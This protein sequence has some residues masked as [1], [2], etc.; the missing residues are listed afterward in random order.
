M[1]TLDPAVN[2]IIIFK[3]ILNPHHDLPLNKRKKGEHLV[4]FPPPLILSR[5]HI[6]IT[7]QVPVPMRS[8]RQ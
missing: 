8:K 6:T 4:D 5:P 3:S 1:T 2:L 7:A